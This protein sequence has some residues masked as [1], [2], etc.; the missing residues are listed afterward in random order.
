MICT[1]SFVQ[2]ND[3]KVSKYKQ[4]IE[5][6]IWRHLLNLLTYTW[7]LFWVLYLLGTEI[8]KGET[9]NSV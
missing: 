6:I 4:N 3:V 2:S 7:N 5:R 9:N 8:S 1:L